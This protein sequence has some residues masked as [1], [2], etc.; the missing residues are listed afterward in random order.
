VHYSFGVFFNS[1]QAEF[2][3]NRAATSSIYSLYVVLSAL[4]AV[5]TGWALDR[6][7]SRPVFFAMG[8]FTTMGLLL[9]SQAH[10][11]LQVFITYSLLLA[12]GTGGIYVASMATIN[13]WF[14]KRRG[15]VMGIVGLASPIGM[16]SMSPFAAY[17]IESHSWQYSFIIVGLIAL[18][19]MIP[20]SLL[21]REPYS[22]RSTSHINDGQETPTYVPHTETPFHIQ[23]S[24]SL[25]EAIRTKNFWLLLSIMFLY[26]SCAYTVT[27]HL[28][29]HAIDMDIL[30][31]KAASLLSIIGGSGIAARLLIGRISDSIGRKRTY[32]ICSL[33]MAISMTWL[34][35]ASELWMLYIFAIIFGIAFGGIAPVH[36]AL[37]GDIFGLR[38]IGIILGLIEMGWQAGAA[39]GAFTAG[40]IFDISGG[41]YTPVFIG[42][43]IVALAVAGLS[44][45]LKEPRNLAR[46]LNI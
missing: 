12:M 11:P 43:I 31:F 15:M 28:V 9:T 5:I 33:L 29:P 45:F 23:G 4:L 20:C 44:W 6:Y 22:K 39:M 2:G 46:S 24:L 38:Y 21:L 26:S 32:I 18:C 3:W 41:S 40:Y 27:A 42:G 19:V 13:R 17:L 37:V 14:T 16:M 34:T 1:M 25:H 36:A 35:I 7:G 8:L 10:S 30:P